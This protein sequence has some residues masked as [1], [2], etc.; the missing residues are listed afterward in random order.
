MSVE[1]FESVETTP[2]ALRLA[3]WVTAWLRGDAVTDLVLDAVI[4][5][6]A[7]HTVSGLAELGLGGED[8]VADTLV[9]G[10]GRLRSEGASLVGVAFPA[11]GDPVGLGGPRAFND[12]A[13]EAGEAV[14]SDV[15]IGLVPVRVGAVV[16]W[17]AHPAQRRQLPDVGEADRALRLALTESATALA[18]L[19][20]ARWRP[21]VADQL[22]NLR[23][24]PTLHGA[25]GV[26]SRCVELAA[27]GVQA[28]GIVD[29]ALEDEG[30]SVTASEMTQR[31]D[32]L[33]GLDRAARRALTAAGSPEVWPP[34]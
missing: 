26:M 19:D 23:H 32:A 30:G 1:E 7:T 17:Q 28:R 4:G 6:D 20:V 11:E 14:V 12:A 33:V 25:P 18:E 16:D 27:G 3:W 22:M 34:A 8:G 13:L 21:E 24:R 15:G 31:R 2:E 9:T 5:P 10:L 29:V